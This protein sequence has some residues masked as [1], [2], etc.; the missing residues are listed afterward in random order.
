MSICT[1]P[2]AC[3]SAWRCLF[4]HD[5]PHCTMLDNPA[6][7]LTVLT[8]GACS[9]SHCSEASSS[10][11]LAQLLEQNAFPDCTTLQ[12]THW[13]YTAYALLCNGSRR[14]S[15]CQMPQAAQHLR[16]G[17]LVCKHA[18][19]D[20]RGTPCGSSVYMHTAICTYAAQAH[21]LKRRQPRCAHWKIGC[22]YAQPPTKG[23]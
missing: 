21:W 3:H 15:P 19:S 4:Y 5:A 6:M 22:R 18:V 14:C 23:A 8:V 17:L 12:T 10:V 2:K 7:S 13:D 11:C 16:L 9:R 20:K 1:A